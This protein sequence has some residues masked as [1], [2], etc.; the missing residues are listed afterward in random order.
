MR[1]DGHVGAE[2]MIILEYNHFWFPTRLPQDVDVLA[3]LDFQISCP[4]T[5]ALYPR[6][7][8]TNHADCE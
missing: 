2:L 3:V 8:F 4:E 7:F 6:S 5:P 1:D